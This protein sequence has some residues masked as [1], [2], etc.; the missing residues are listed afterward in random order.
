MVEQAPHV[1]DC[2]TAAPLDPQFGDFEPIGRAEVNFLLLT[3]LAITAFGVPLK[4]SFATLTA[5][6]LLY[7]GAATAMGLLIS[8]FMHSQVAAIFGTAVL[9]ILPAVQFSGL[10]DPVAS[11]EGAGALIGRIYPTTY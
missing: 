1:V 10:L 8:T 3:L 5:A 2:G 4:G 7:V 6:T 9:T 11:L